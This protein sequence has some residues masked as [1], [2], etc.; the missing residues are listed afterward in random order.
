[1]LYELRELAAANDRERFARFDAMFHDELGYGST[2][3]CE[4]R[5]SAAATSS[6]SGVGHLLRG[7][8]VEIGGAVAAI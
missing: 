6:C 3:K 1:M 5:P 2:R 7:A 4:C 8:D